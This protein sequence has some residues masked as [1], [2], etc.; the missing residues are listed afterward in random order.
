LSAQEQL[1]VAVAVV[2]DFD[3]SNLMQPALHF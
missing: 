1:A 2:A 3:I